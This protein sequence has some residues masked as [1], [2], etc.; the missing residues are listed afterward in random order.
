[1]LRSTILIKSVVIL[2]FLLL[3]GFLYYCCSPEGNAWYPKCSF[4][5]LTGWQC[6]SCGSQRAVHALLHG[7]VGQA[8]RYNPFMLVSIPYAVGVVLSTMWASP[9]AKRMR[10]ALLHR[11]VVLAYVV[12]FVAWWVLRNIL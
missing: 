3:L 11:N 6:P 4:Y 12:L 2:L 8:L 10:A 5:L 9:W 1:M 7:E